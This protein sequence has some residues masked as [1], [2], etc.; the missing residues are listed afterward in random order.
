[1]IICISICFFI[2]IISE[3][4]QVAAGFQTFKNFKKSKQLKIAKFEKNTKIQKIK[5]KGNKGISI[6]RLFK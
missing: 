5:I 6:T 3:K 4:A 1:M 2:G